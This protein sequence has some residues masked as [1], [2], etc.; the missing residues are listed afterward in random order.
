MAAIIRI[1]HCRTLTEATLS[2]WFFGFG[3]FLAGLWWI[4]AAFLVEA[5]YQ[6]AMPF[7]VIGLPLILALFYALAFGLCFRFWRSGLH[8]IIL[9]SLL[10]TA[11]ELLRAS[12]FTGFPWNALGMLLGTEL[13][14]AQITSVIGLYG[15]TFFVV[16]LGSLPVLLFTEQ[17]RSRRALGPLLSLIGLM[18]LYGFGH[19]RLDSASADFVPNTRI[20]IM[21]PSIAQDEKFDQA[22]SANILSLYLSLS[23]KGS[24]PSPHGMEGITHLIWPETAFPFLLDQSPKARE[25]IARILP[26]GA[27]LLT[28]AVRAEQGSAQSGR[29]YFNSIQMLDDSGVIK[30]SADKVHL[31]PFGEYLPLSG[32]LDFF[33]LRDFITAPGGF[34]PGAQRDPL[35]VPAWPPALPLICYEAIFPDESRLTNGKRA[36][37]LLNVTNDAWFGFTPGPSQHYA[38][39]R[40][41]A[42]EYGAP[43]IR[44]GNN[45]ISAIIDPYGREIARI[46][47]GA[48]GIIDGPLPAALPKTPYARLSDGPFS[49]WSLFMGLIGILFTIGQITPRRA[50]SIRATSDR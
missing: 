44:A 36:G 23:S 22:N 34:I 19:Q 43:L 25:E 33:G 47:L 38:Q 24:Y 42:I 29:D 37:V 49:P 41:R 2:G 12:L 11:T 8:R 31:V 27:V 14:F 46:D 35:L 7:A 26:K 3:Y 30:A 1:D 17:A 18:A 21:Q 15:L 45:G 13:V 4:G 40:L 48:R 20:R 10:M 16:L 39:A 9:F 50:V 5:R 32:A 28:G 6:W